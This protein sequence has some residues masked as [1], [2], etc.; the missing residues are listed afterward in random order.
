MEG[1]SSY[2]R[3][4]ERENVEA[5]ARYLSTHDGLTGLPNRMMFDQILDHAVKVGR[6]YQEQ[7]CVM[8]IDLYRFKFINDTL[9]H[10]MT[11]AIL[12][13]G[14]ALDVQL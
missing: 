7:F 10:A 8:F 5:R 2:A 4:T 14:L 1:R 12:T 9:G 11:K 6:R 3:T 13:L